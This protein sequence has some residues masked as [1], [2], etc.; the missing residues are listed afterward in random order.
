MPGALITGATG[1]VGSHLVDRLLA[2]GWRVRCTVRRTSDVTWLSGKS[3]EPVEGDLREGAGLVR[4]MAG[5]DVVFHLAGVLSAPTLPM[6]RAGN[7]RVARNVVE[8]AV[9]AGVRRLVHVSTLAAAGPSRDGRPVDEETPCAPI[10]KYGLSKLEGE[11]EVWKHRAEIGVTVIRPPAVYGPR[12][13]GLRDLFRILAAGVQPVLG[14]PK[15][16]SIIHVD[17]LV[18]GIVDAAEHPKA[19]GEV[20]FVANERAHSFSE[21]MGWIAGAAGR[22]PVRLYVHDEV[23]R[24]FGSVAES[25][26]LGRGSVFTRDKALEMT[27]ARWVCSAQKAR[28]LLG[29]RAR[30]PI[31][32]GLRA[33]MAWYR[34]AGWI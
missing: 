11:R 8:A 6:Y 21:L 3:I 32:E 31:E 28:R 34:G 26:P 25:L 30:V 17:D 12:D 9:G 22:A 19:V 18:R 16:V 33:T 13:R 24:F 5:V 27:Q 4:A 29:W 23:L 10:S 7:W 2:C 15:F 20:F 14:G 1:F